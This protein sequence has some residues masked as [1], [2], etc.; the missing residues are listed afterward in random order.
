METRITVGQ[1]N[2]SKDNSAGKEHDTFVIL[3]QSL[4]NAESGTWVFLSKYNK[5]LWD[6]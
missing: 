2:H 4:N 3:R 1:E 6:R 5:E